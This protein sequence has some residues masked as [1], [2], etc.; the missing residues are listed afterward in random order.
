MYLVG[1]DMDFCQ[2]CGTRMEHLKKKQAR[3]VTLILSCPRC[4]YEKRSTRQ[5]PGKS[6]VKNHLKD[7]LVVIG[8]KEQRLRTVPTLAIDCP[9]CRNN[10]AYVWMVH[11]GKLEE[12]TTKFHRCTKCGYTIRDKT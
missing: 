5:N 7:N 10:R 11:L 1:I 9:K 2:N 3:I 8:K 4:G 12:D 6:N